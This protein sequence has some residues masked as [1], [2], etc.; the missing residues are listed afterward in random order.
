MATNV[1]NSLYPGSTHQDYEDLHDVQKPFAPKILPNI[2]QT[3]TENQTANESKSKSSYQKN[4][5]CGK[6]LG[7]LSGYQDISDQSMDYE[8]AESVIHL[9]SNFVSKHDSDIFD[10]NYDKSKKKSEKMKKKSSSD[11]VSLCRPTLMYA[12]KSESLK[13]KGEDVKK[14]SK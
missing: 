4:Q 5:T 3:T 10:S 12:N 9:T 6:S 14:Y 8:Y 1:I 11:L 2:S 13:K 7:M